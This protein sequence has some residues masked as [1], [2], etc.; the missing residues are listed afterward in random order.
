MK[1]FFGVTS[2][3]RASCIFV[4][5]LAAIFLSQTTLGAIFAQILIDFLGFAR[6]LDKS[7]LM[8]LFLYPLHPAFYTTG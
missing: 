2:K 5:T 1:T 6:T 7:K 4:Q 3:E 8:V